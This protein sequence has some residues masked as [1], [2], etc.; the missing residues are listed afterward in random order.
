MCTFCKDSYHTQ[1]DCPKLHFMPLK[2]FIIMK[3]LNNENKFK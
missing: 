2:Q 1:F 3:Y